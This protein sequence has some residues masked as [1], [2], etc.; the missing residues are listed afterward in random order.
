MKKSTRLV[1]LKVCNVRIIIVLILAKLKTFKL[2][3]E[4]NR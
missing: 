3:N 1:H 4:E 2:D